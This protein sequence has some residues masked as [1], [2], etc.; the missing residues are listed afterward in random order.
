MQCRIHF[1]LYFQR[2]VWKRKCALWDSM[3]LFGFPP[4]D[5][6]QERQQYRHRRIHLW[7]NQEYNEPQLAPLTEKLSYPN[8]RS[9]WYRHSTR[10]VLRQLAS[11]SQ[12]HQTNHLPFAA[13]YG[14]LLLR[15]HQPEYHCLKEFVRSAHQNMTLYEPLRLWYHPYKSAQLK[16]TTCHP[17]QIERQPYLRNHVSSLDH[18][19]IHAHLF[20][21][22]SLPF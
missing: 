6:S 7:N 15:G 8:N 14:S 21:G 17:F 12:K 4:H 11:G 10:Q 2:F 1:E 16:D 5:P 3:E 9:Q 22:A 18:R 20:Y 19:K 13:W